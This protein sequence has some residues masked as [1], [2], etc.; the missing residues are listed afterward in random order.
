MEQYEHSEL[1]EANVK[2]ISNIAGTAGFRG[3]PDDLAPTR[4]FVVADL[5]SEL[6]A[7]YK[8][9]SPAAPTLLGQQPLQPNLMPLSF[10]SGEFEG[11]DHK[12]FIH[13]LWIANNG[14]VV[15]AVTSEEAEVV[16]ND[17]ISF[18]DSSFEF[19]IAK[20]TIR[21][22]FTAKVVVKF[23]E[24]LEKYLRGL[25]TANQIVRE[26]LSVPGEEPYSIKRLAFGK[27]IWSPQNVSA[28]PGLFSL[29]A[30]DLM[31]FLIERRV[32]HPFIDNRYFV[33]APIGTQKTVKTLQAL[34]TALSG[35]MI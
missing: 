11:G 7:R 9:P 13:G 4:A 10:S 12:V 25:E 24:P 19:Q 15:Q 22:E 26:A 14:A 27:E 35:S 21:R 3:S 34:E 29:E 30:F 33:H 16:L 23:D 31:D 1:A 20:S 28:I 32:N 18:L 5:I 17:L 8:F 2:L 6:T